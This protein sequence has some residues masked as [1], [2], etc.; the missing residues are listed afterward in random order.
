MKSTAL[1]RSQMDEL[2]VWRSLSL[3]KMPYLASTLLALRPLDAPGLGT[4]A[5]DATLRLYVDFEAVTPKGPVWCA[6]ALLHECCHIFGDHAARSDDAAVAADE[7]QMWNLSADA[8]ANDDLAAAGCQTIEVDGILPGTLG[9]ED[10]QT[11]EFYLAALRRRRAARRSQAR[12]GGSQAAQRWR[13][14]PYRGSGPAAG[15]RPVRRVWVGVGRD[16]RA[17]RD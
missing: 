1:S 16:G 6:E 7:R 14:A 4:F 10:H 11:A 8:E 15:D 17:M 9:E 2:V 12:P 3:E 13:T 5:V